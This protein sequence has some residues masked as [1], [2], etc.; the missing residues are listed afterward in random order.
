MYPGLCREARFLAFLGIAP[1]HSTQVCPDHRVAQ[2]SWTQF[3]TWTQGST[4][5]LQGPLQAPGNLQKAWNRAALSGLCRVD[6]E[7]CRPMAELRV[8]ENHELLE[9]RELHGV[10]V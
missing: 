1:Q 9:P 2:S 6:T 4:S 7:G 8:S 5:L 3:S 10:P